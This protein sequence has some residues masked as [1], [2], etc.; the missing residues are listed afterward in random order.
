MHPKERNVRETSQRRAIRDALELADRP[1]SAT[2]ILHAARLAVPQLG[3][4][5]VYRAVKSLHGD[6]ALH[7]VDLPGDSP[8]Y[9]LSGKQHHHHFHCRLC[10]RVY[11]VDACPG[12]LLN[13][14]PPGFSLEA[15]E[16]ILYG[17]CP[18]CTPKKARQR[19]K[20]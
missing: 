12:E 5:T 20:G 8:R 19:R 4:A 10:K 15:H 11:E 16:I 6:G 9:E 2:E 14:A 3:V 18:T 13:L 17:R 7:Q 1:L